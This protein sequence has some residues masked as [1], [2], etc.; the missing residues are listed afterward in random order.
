MV[1]VTSSSSLSSTSTQV[2]STVNDVVPVDSQHPANISQTKP[3]SCA[4]TRVPPVVHN[5]NHN[6]IVNFVGSGKLIV[7]SF[8]SD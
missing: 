6:D 7:R 1:T 2:S 8:F 4:E 5:H 3:T